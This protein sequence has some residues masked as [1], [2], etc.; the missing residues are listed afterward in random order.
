MHI[1]KENEFSEEEDKENIK[2]AME[3]FRSKRGRKWRKRKANVLMFIFIALTQYV[4]QE[5]FFVLLQ[6]KRAK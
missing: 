5:I 4:N 6:M 2:V 1:E 3:I